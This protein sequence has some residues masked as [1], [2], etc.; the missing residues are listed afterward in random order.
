MIKT[1]RVL[2]R[3][4]GFARPKP[5]TRLGLNLRR[6]KRLVLILLLFYAGLLTYPQ[7]LFGHCV[8]VS[9]ITLYSRSPLPPQAAVSMSEAASLVARC[10]LAVPGR[11]ERVF[12]CDTPWM[13]R[14]FHW[15]RPEAFAYSMPLTDH[16]FIASADF[17]RGLA[18]RRAPDFNTRSL[19]AVMAHEITHGLIRRR[20]G[21]F[22]A[23]LIPDWVAEGYCD[24]VAQESSFPEAE[25][26]R[27]LT[28]Y[29]DHPSMAYRYFLY[30]KMVSYL[31]EQQHLSFDQIAARAGDYANVERQ[32]RLALQTRQLQ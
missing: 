30:R 24:Y 18:I 3:F 2:L 25:G 20:Q 13:F 28:A 5:R 23:I 16:V 31:I 22:R 9:G 26:L 7:V 6:C 10:D 11:H 32:T 17:A 15:A 12:V 27:R 19:S 29:D 8:T 14:L 4:F 21:L 1:F